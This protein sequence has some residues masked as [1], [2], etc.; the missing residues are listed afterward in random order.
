MAPD[1]YSVE[2]AAGLLDCTAETTVERIAT[3]DVPGVKIGRSWIIP[4]EAFIQ[5]LNEMALQD[6]QSRRALR[7]AGKTAGK[8][9]QQAREPKAG[10]ARIPP[11]LPS[12]V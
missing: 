7:V 9:I 3:G 4:R 10:R 11:S 12:G 8:V 5:R 2:E 1:F 6:A